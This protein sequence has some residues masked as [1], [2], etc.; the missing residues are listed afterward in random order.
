MSRA[1]AL[2]ASWHSMRPKRALEYPVYPK[3]IVGPDPSLDGET[4]P[5]ATYFEAVDEI[6]LRSRLPDTF[7]PRGGEAWALSIDAR[8]SEERD[9]IPR[10]EL[11]GLFQF[12]QAA[13]D[14][15]AWVILGEQDLVVIRETDAYHRL[16]GLESEEPPNG[17]IDGPH[18]RTQTEGTEPI[19]GR[20]R[21]RPGKM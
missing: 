10:L 2:I 1:Y 21:T 16:G 9:A 6:A 18:R 4:R 8:V 11:R 7:H 15:V 3:T 12:E 13:A 17:N 19:R 5:C 20:S 14:D